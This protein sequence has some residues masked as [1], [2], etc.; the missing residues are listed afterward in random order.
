MANHEL[1]EKDFILF[2]KKSFIHGHLALTLCQ[3]KILLDVGVR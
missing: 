3:V 1:M 2:F